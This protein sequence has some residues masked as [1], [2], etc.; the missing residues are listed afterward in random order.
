[1]ECLRFASAVSALKCLKLG[2]RAGIHL[3]TKAQTGNDYSDTW[4][5]R[6]K[7]AAKYK[8]MMKR[9]NT[10]GQSPV[11]QITI[12]LALFGG[13]AA[14]VE[15]RHIDFVYHVKKYCYTWEYNINLLNWRHRYTGIGTLEF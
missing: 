10:P 3:R 6:W 15:K 7:D 4:N 14:K 13:P 5:L 8:V 9:I 11:T 2:G 12:P 1:M